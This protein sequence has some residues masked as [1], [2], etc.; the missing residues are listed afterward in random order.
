[1]GSVKLYLFS[2]IALVL[3]A[4]DCPDKIPL[5]E[6]LPARKTGVKFRNN[7]TEDSQ[8]NILTYEYFYNGGGVAA[9]DIN[10]DGLDDLFFT[11]NMTDNILYLNE[12][13]FRFSD[14]TKTAGI[15][16]PARSWATGVTMADINGD[17][18][19]DIYV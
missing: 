7:L 3:M 15:I 13:N 12:G 4:A 8:N 11:G 5:F 9:G 2:S 14:I 16:N 18:W 6:N 1:M 19:L 10:N 17:G